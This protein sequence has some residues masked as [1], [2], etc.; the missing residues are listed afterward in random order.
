MIDLGQYADLKVLR[1]L[2]HGAYL[3]AGDGQDVLLPIK[4]LGEETQVDDILHVFV[5]KDS[6]NRPVAT[7]H[8]PKI[9]VG[10]YATLEVKDV[11]QY[12]AFLDWGI[13]NQ[14]LVPFAEQEDR[15]KAGNK[16]VVTMYVDKI[17]DR[18]VASS[19]I[20]RHIKKVTIELKAGEP[21]K[22]L[23]YGKTENAY[24]AIVNGEFRG[25]L[26][27]TEAFRELLYG[28]SLDGFIKVIREDGRIDL[29]MSRP[30][31]QGLE[32]SAD[33]ILRFLESNGGFV[34][35]TDDSDP[36]EIARVLGIS[37]KRFKKG[38]GVLYKERRVEI[39]PNGVKLI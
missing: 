15:M 11:N 20:D 4:E 17:T 23:V 16:Y 28:E 38:V 9:V 13:E 30:G 19:K 27:Y 24:K 1:I 2:P 18:L 21:A 36:E 39:L 34:G 5:Y 14:L 35:L 10:G 31:W 22:L 32:E 12:G 7:V 29:S 25:M 3:D 26:Y 33:L 37:K 6:D 8:D